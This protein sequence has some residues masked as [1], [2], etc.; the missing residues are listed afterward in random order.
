[1]SHD[2]PAIGALDPA[3]RDVPSEVR[4]FHFDRSLLLVVEALAGRLAQTE[5]SA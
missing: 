5:S 3:L 4:Y 1:M 2:D